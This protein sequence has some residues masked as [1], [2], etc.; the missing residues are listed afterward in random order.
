MCVYVRLSRSKAA[1]FRQRAEQNQG[2][3][4][5]NT[6]QTRTTHNH[7]RAHPRARRQ[8]VARVIVE[9]ALDA[10]FLESA[11]Q[12]R[13]KGFLVLACA[14]EVIFACDLVGAIFMIAY[15][16][17]CM[18]RRIYS[19]VST[20]NAGSMH[21]CA[22]TSINVSRAPKR[23]DMQALQ[24]PQTTQSCDKLDNICLMHRTKYMQTKTKARASVRQKHVIRFEN[25]LLCRHVLLRRSVRG[26]VNTQMQ[27]QEQQQPHQ[28]ITGRCMMPHFPPRTGLGDSAVAI[29]L[30]PCR[31]S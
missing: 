11:R 17:R 6:T 20:Q 14:C 28:H 30:R 1:R 9:E 10:Q 24:M 7:G 26:H 5:N 13:H 4:N 31:I 16:L 29:L 18:W 3:C 19:T 15:A 2:A 27:L 22:R 25:R 23:M 12:P 8:R 21:A